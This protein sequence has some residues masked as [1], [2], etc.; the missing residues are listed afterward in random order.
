MII[1]D[2]VC[3]NSCSIWGGSIDDGGSLARWLF[4]MWSALHSTARGCWLAGR[5]TN[6]NSSY[7]LSGPEFM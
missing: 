2:D 4:A 7:G 5:K 6:L 3:D 1:Y